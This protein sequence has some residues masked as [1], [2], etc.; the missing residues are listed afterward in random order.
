MGCKKRKWAAKHKGPSPKARRVSTRARP[1]RVSSSLCCCCPSSSESSPPIS[2]PATQSSHQNKVL[3]TAHAASST[4][5]LK[6]TPLSRAPAMPPPHSSISKQPP[7]RPPA[8]HKQPI[9]PPLK[10]E[11]QSKLPQEPPPATHPRKP[12]PNH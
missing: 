9:T 6:R 2:R 8:P 4:P 10:P 3:R 1:V 5:H 12:R 7:Q 11:K